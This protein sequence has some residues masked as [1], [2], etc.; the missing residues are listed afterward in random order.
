VPLFAGLSR[1]ELANS[2]GPEALRDGLAA[3]TETAVPGVP[4]LSDAFEGREHDR[5]AIASCA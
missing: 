3:V 1:I 5:G 2:F 4:S